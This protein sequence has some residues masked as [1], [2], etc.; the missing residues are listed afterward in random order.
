MNT[1]LSCL[2][3]FGLLSMA[4][5]GT[6]SVPLDNVHPTSYEFTIDSAHPQGVFA[7]KTDTASGILNCNTCKDFYTAKGCVKL[8]SRKGDSGTPQTCT[9]GY[10][11]LARK[12]SGKLCTTDRDVFS[13]TNEVD[14]SNKPTC[15][16]CVAK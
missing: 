2:I 7:I 3:T 6:T 5:A 4:Q 11:P 13:C 8:T 16:G 12:Q 14:S 1:I 15:N 10:V 9:K